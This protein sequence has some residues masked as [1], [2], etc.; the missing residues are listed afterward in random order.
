MKARGLFRF[1]AR[2]ANESASNRLNFLSTFSGT[3]FVTPRTVRGR[4]E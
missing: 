1:F 4:S 2:T 3:H